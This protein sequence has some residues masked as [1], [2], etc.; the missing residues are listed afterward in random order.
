LFVA[1]GVAGAIVLRKQLRLTVLLLL[2]VV[3]FVTYPSGTAILVC[4]VTAATLWMTKARGSALRPYAVG[5]VL[6]LTLVLAL[7]NFGWGVRLS[8]DYFQAVGK[9]DTTSTREALWQAGIEKFQS[10]PVV[11]RNFSG[12]ARVATRRVPG[13]RVIELPYHND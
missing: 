3:I 12:G 7:S 8:S 4:L 2:V 1:I 6:A 13:G 11:G 5:G 9:S 10:S